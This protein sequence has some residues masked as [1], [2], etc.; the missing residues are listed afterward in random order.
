[1]AN[2]SLFK[3]KHQLFV[4]MIILLLLCS[5]ACVSLAPSVHAATQSALQQKGMSILSNVVGIDVTKYAITSKEYPQNQTGAYPFVV[6]EEKVGYTLSSGT[7]N[8]NV[9]YS[10]ANG[11]LLMIQVLENRGVPTLTKEITN[12]SANELAKNFL[13]NYQKYTNN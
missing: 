4:T 7:S 2:G 12:A 3:E 10:F 11:N 13:D 5:T 6:S 1:M 8:L 9:L